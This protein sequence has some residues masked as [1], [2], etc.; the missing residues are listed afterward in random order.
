MPAKLNKPEN[1]DIFCDIRV[2]NVG[3][4]LAVSMTETKNLLLKMFEKKEKNDFCFRN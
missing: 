2:A 1:L 3:Q 4:F